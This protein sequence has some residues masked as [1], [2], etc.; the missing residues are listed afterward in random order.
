VRAAGGKVGVVNLPEAGIKG[1]SH[2]LMMNRTTAKP[3]T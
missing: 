1:S 3:P 2:M